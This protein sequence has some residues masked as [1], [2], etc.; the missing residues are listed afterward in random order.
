MALLVSLVVNDTPGD[1][2]G[3]GAAAAF[4]IRRFEERNP[5]RVDEIP[6]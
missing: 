4:A 2:L 6:L 5:T 1:V 3:M